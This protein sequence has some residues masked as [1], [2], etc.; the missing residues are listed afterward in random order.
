MFDVDTIEAMTDEQAQNLVGKFTTH[1]GVECPV[2]WTD[3]AMVGIAE[4]M[5]FA[6]G[7]LA[8]L[9]HL[10]AIGH[11]RPEASAKG[12]IEFLSHLERRRMWQANSQRHDLK[13]HASRLEA[14][15]GILPADLD[16]CD[17]VDLELLITQSD[18]REVR[19]RGYTLLM[20]K[21][22]EEKL[23]RLRDSQ[24]ERLKETAQAN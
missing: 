20:I 23:E 6:S 9:S 8:G 14:E 1:I 4:S 11:V 15:S 3:S 2:R 21:R 17:S 10:R 7:Q 16:S 13:K 22:G 19:E 24:A 18:S 12:C 5:E